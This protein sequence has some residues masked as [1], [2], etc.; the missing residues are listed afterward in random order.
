MFKKI[1]YFCLFVMLAGCTNAAG[2]ELVGWWPLDDGAGTTAVDSSGT[3][4]NGT[5]TGTATWVEGK[6]GGGLQL[7]GSNNYIT[8]SHIALD[9]RSFTIAMWIKPSVLS[10]NHDLFAQGTAGTNTLLHIRLTGPNAQ[11]TPANIV[12]FA[13]YNGDTDSPANLIQVDKWYH[14]ACV[15]NINTMTR[16]IYINGEQVGQGAAASAFLGTTGDPQFGAGTMLGGEYFNG[17]LDDIRVYTS[18]LSAEDIIA[19]MTGVKGLALN[20]QPSNGAKEIPIDVGGIS[21]TPG[22]FVSTDGGTHNVFYG[23]DEASVTNATIAEPLGTTLYQGLDVNNIALDRLEYGTTYYWRVDEVNIPSKPG[24]STGNVWNFT[25]ELEGYPLEPAQIVNVTA[26]ENPVYPDEQEPNMTCNESG[27]DANDLHSTELA[28]MWLGMAD[29][30]GQ[31][32]IQ[33]EFDRV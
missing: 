7:S 6:V 22:E 32:W 14:I 25:T 20:P 15:F 3:G 16:S 4:N 10:A 26:S 30:P 21:W 1:I 12:R 33:Y 17:V 9:N 28:T 19:V 27:L 23:T 8:A 11:Y 24:T 13:F 2:Q 31:V 18:A 29:E 5:V